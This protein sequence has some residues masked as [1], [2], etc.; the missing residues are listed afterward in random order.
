[1][2][3]RIGIG[4]VRKTRAVELGFGPGAEGLVLQGTPGEGGLDECEESELERWGGTEKQ[5][6]DEGMVSNNIRIRIQSRTGHDQ[7][8]LFWRQPKGKG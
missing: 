2:Q 1:M 7:S 3:M 8:T 4:V 5:Q 6:T